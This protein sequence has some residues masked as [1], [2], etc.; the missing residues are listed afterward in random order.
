MYGLYS[1]LSGGL[2]Y[3]V[4]GTVRQITIGPSAILSLMTFYYAAEDPA[5]VAILTFFSGI[6]QTAFG[7]FRLDI[8]LD[9]SYP[10]RSTPVTL[11]TSTVSYSSNPWSTPSKQD[12]VFPTFISLL[13]ELRHLNIPL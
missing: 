4:L 3:A 10:K 8:S 2:A 6:I 9:L 1:S 7:V 12:P 11:P 13:I 5:A